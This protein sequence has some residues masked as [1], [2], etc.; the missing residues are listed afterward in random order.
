MGAWGNSKRIIEKDETKIW[1]ENGASYTRFRYKG[2][3]GEYILRWNIFGN[4]HASVYV[5]EGFPSAIQTR[6]CV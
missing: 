6:D 2:F 3:S 4:I 1:N 5:C